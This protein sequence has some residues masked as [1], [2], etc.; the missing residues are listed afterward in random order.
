M[1]QIDTEY[2]AQTFLLFGLEVVFQVQA[3]KIV[4]N[5]LWLEV[6]SAKDK[7]VSYIGLICG[8]ADWIAGQFG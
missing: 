7:G 2:V 3:K 4:S 1:L 6:V 8:K 5:M